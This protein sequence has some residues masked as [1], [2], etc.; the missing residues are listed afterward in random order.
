MAHSLFKR[1][2]QSLGIVQPDAHTDLLESRLGV[3]YCFGTWS[4]H[5]NALLGGAGKLVQVGIRNSGKTKAHWESTLGVKQFWADEILAQPSDQTI[6]EITGHLHRAGVKEIYFS[7]DIDGTDGLE[8]SATGTPESK[9]PSSQFFM[10]LIE[11]LKGEF[12]WVGADLVELAPDLG[13]TPKDAER[14]CLLSARY[15]FQSIEALLEP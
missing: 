13:P 7:N 5:A 14:T 6:Q 10:E 4:F 3:K 11:A 2:G 12:T 9:G 15:A 8:M 1:Y